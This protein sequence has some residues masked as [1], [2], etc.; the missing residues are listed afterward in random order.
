MADTHAKNEPAGIRTKLSR[1]AAAIG[2]M[3]WLLQRLRKRERVFERAYVTQAWGSSESGSGVGSELD[4]TRNLQAYLPELF[5]RL[6]IKTFLDAPC[7]DWNWMRKVDLTQVE[8]IGADVVSSV[9]TKNTNKYARSNIRFL[10]ADLTKDL[11]PSADLI[12]CRDCWVHLSYQDISA[13]LENFRRTGAN[14]LLVSD[15]PSAESNVNKL[16]GI[17]WRHINLSLPP[18]CFPPPEERR[19]DHYDFE[20]IQISLWRLSILPTIKL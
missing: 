20:P 3:Q 18:F 10:Q 11:L 5:N 6:A 13:M 2:P 7:G 19:K 16:T 12:L 15:T 1:S 9:I 8:Y 17:G 4:A 14:W